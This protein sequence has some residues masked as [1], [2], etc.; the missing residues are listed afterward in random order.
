M[1][2]KEQHFGLGEDNEVSVEI[3]W[4]NE[5]VFTVKNLASN[6]SYE[7]TYPETIKVINKK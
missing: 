5:Q 6:A 7:I 4:S 2:P 3:R 1:H